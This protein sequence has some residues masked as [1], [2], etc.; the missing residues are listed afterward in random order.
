MNIQI[1]KNYIPIARDIVK[2]NFNNKNFFHVSII[3]TKTGQYLS[4]GVNGTKTHPLNQRFNYRNNEIHSE[5]AA[6]L[7]IR[8][9]ETPFNLINF[10]FNKQFE[11]RLSKPCNCCMNLLSTIGNLN[12]IWYS[13]NEGEMKRI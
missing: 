8:W 6:Y 1:V 12:E 5:L 13:T 4:C 2:L 11:L 3:T 9:K 7:G 10:R